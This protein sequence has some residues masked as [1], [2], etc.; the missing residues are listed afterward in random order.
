MSVID[1]AIISPFLSTIGIHP[2]DPTFGR[3]L[4]EPSDEENKYIYSNPDIRVR[5]R[6]VFT[7]PSPIEGAHINVGEGEDVKCTAEE[8]KNVRGKEWTFYKTMELDTPEAAQGKA[9]GS[10]LV[11]LHGVYF[12]ILYSRF[13]H[14]PPIRRNV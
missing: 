2:P 8:L 3:Y 7:T 1:E 9:R 11:V 6:R 13:V 10:D 5:M 12:S 14:R 4:M